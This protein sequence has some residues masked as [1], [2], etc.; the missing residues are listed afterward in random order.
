[1]G[2][3]GTTMRRGER[4]LRLVE[5]VAVAEV[6]GGIR[7]DVRSRDKRLSAA[8]LRSGLAHGLLR[9]AGAILLNA[10]T[11]SSF[12]V[13]IRLEVRGCGVCSDVVVVCFRLLLHNS[14]QRPSVQGV[15]A[16]TNQ[17][18]C[19]ST[20]LTLKTVLTTKAFWSVKT[21][22]V[23]DSVFERVNARHSEPKVIIIVKNVHLH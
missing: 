20:A 21:R 7:G 14:H 2:E 10:L 5:L 8:S 18:Q 6:V 4:F 19:V 11:V 16:G 23:Y 17:I 9:E 12:M 13:F 15:L 1:M 22:L 3:D